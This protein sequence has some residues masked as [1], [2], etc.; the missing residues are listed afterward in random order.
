MTEIVEYANLPRA[1]D[2]LIEAKRNLLKASYYLHEL[3]EGSQIMLQG[4]MA[5]LT[6][7]LAQTTES[8]L[9]L[10][11]REFASGHIST[12]ASV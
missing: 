9:D 5:L 2:A 3:T 7:G 10:L 8:L 11:H 1:T 6:G 12:R 4:D